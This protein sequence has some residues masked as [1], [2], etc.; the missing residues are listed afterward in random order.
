MQSQDIFVSPEV[1]TVV[2]IQI[3]SVRDVDLPVV[4]V[5]A[6]R[7]HLHVCPLAAAAAAQY[8]VYMFDLVS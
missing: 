8:A 7:G 4:D 3:G 2:G 1:M 5:R 6:P